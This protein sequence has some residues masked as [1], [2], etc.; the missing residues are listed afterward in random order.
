MLQGA[1]TT[2]TL[3]ARV[4][5]DAKSKAD[6]IVP[7]SNVEMMD[8]TNAITWGSDDT[9]V[10]N[11]IMTPLAENQLHTYLHL[12]SR[13]VDMLRT[14]APDLIRT[15]VNRLLQTKGDD[16]RMLRTLNGQVRAW[17]SNGYHRLDYVD[18]LKRVLP[19]VQEAGY[20]I[21]SAQVTDNRLYLHAV[22]PKAEGEIRLHD[23]V[24]FG[25]VISDS[26][27]GKGRLSIQLFMERLVCT[28]GMIVPEF[29]KRRAHIG[30]RV[31]ADDE[32]L[33]A[34]SSETTKAAD[35]AL[36]FGLRDHIKEFSTPEGIK[37]IMDRLKE[38][39]E[40]PV[41]GDPK[42]VVEVLA[43][44]FLLNEKES[45]DVLYNFLEGQDRT[46][47][48]L[49]N[50]ITAVAN[51]YGHDYDRGVEIE[52]IGGQVLMS[53]AAEWKAISTAKA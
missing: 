2:S 5:E 24:R 25:W 37:R 49:S 11:E 46:R 41:S 40:A 4:I 32:Y 45:T 26:E 13:F 44:K 36:W 31:D 22:S 21:T 6:Y 28:N 47:F 17:L 43:N 8:D 51:H 39:T 3:V 42:A 15:N 16:K 27:V 34:V 9:A 29:S 23:P 53:D 48:G 50:A 19:M 18:V 7:A 10:Y 33:V 38:Q 20:Q 1:L 14:D 52:Q 12:P 30:G 35:D